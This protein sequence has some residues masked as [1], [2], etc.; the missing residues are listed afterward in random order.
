MGVV[1][2]GINWIGVHS[3]QILDL[4][5]Q[6]RGSE[7]VG[8][9]KFLGKFI[10]E[11][12]LVQLSVYVIDRTEHTGLKFELPAKDVHEKLHNSIHRS[13]G[14]GEEQETNHD[15]LFLDKS[16]GL[17][18]RLVVNK[19]REESE[20]V[21]HVGLG[22]IVSDNSLEGQLSKFIPG[23]CRTAWWCG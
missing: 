8:V 4:K 20:D 6:E 13:Q 21:E 14:V 2:A 7:L 23:Q 16:E 5:L 3:A 22:S 9:T 18:Q 19:D 12:L 17:V 11:T 10:C 1:V 15:R